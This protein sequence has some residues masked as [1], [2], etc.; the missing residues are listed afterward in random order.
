MFRAVNWLMAGLFA[1]ATVVQY[2]DPDPVRWMAI[3]GAAMLV[4]A[5]VGWRGTVPAVVPILVGAVALIWGVFWSMGGGG[6]ATYSHMFDHWEMQNVPIEEA[7]ETSGLFIVAAWM[8]VVAV[9]EWRRARAI[10]KTA[11]R[12]QEAAAGMPLRGDSGR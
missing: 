5:A 3:Y 10:S 9:R 6:A 4:A 1:L 2:N 7:R 11:A 12:F 8:A